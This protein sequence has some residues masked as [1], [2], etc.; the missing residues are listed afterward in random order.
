MS[1][2]KI[3]KDYLINYQADGLKEITIAPAA[4]TLAPFIEWC[5]IREL[6]KFTTDDIYD[7]LDFINAYTYIKVGKAIKYSTDTQQKIRTVLKKF[8]TFV[9]HELEP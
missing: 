3:L 7:Y 4:T 5:G 9:N 1:N 6:E 8:L 2:A